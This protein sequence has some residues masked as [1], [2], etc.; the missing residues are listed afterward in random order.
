MRRLGGVVE[1]DR[2]GDRIV[3]RDRRARLQRG[4]GDTVVVDVDRDRA[5]GRFH[6]AGNRHLVAAGPDVAD[7]PRRLFVQH[8]LGTDGIPG[9][10]HGRQRLVPEFDQ[11]GRVVRGRLGFGEDR[12]DRLSDMAHPVARE[13]PAGRL[14]HR[15]SVLGRDLPETRHRADPDRRHIRPGQHRRH[16]GDGER[17]GRLD[18][19]YL[20]MGV[21]GSDEA[22]LE[23]AGD[24]AIRHVLSPAGQEPPVLK[25]ENRCA[26]T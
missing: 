4:A 18:T 3:G 20:R 12:G 14:R 8:G 6:C 1:R 16:A 19:Q 5:C 21:V 24:G 15:R 2:P 22:A 17:R 7:I 9:T 26:D 10:D 25:T 13:R 11:L 23:R